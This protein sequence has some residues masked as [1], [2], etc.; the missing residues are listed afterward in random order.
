MTGLLT[1]LS[2]PIALLLLLLLL[3]IGARCARLGESE[4]TPPIQRPQPHRT[5]PGR[6][7]KIKELETK[8]KE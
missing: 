3:L 8:K 7:K 4:N 5:N 6:K 2:T 1:S